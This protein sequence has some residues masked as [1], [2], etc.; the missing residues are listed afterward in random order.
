VFDAQ[1]REALFAPNGD[2][3]AGEGVAS[4]VRFCRDE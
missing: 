4:L 1:A 3:I 2:I